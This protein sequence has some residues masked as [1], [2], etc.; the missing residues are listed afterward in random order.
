MDRQLQLVMMGLIGLIFSPTVLGATMYSTK[1][2]Y[3]GPGI[4]YGPGKINDVGI[5][6]VTITGI[7]FP[8]PMHY[9]TPYVN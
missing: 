8:A 9:I 2:S 7:G 6:D 3:M 5:F 1:D 4:F